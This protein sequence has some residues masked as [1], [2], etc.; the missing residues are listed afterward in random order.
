MSL[1][2][3][4]G[5]HQNLLVTSALFFTIGFANC[6]PDTVINGA[7]TSDLAQDNGAR[8]TSLVNGIGTIGGLVEGPVVG[9]LIENYN[10]NTVILVLI[11][12]SILPAIILFRLKS[13]STGEPKKNKSTIV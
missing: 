9:L 2:S 10:W 8:V 13:A 4:F 11:F 6:G 7:I 3:V 12:A 1:T 5:H